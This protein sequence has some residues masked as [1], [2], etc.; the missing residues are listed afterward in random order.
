MEVAVIVY[1]II[2][3]LV[4]LVAAIPVIMG[5]YIYKDAKKR[6]MNAALWTLIGVLAPGFIGLI[7]YLIV[8]GE[9]SD[10]QCNSCGKP[11]STAFSVC[12]YC[13]APLKEKCSKCGYTLNPDWMVCANCGTEIPEEH[14]HRTTVRKKSGGLKWLLALVIAVPL[15]LMVLLFA[16]TC[17]FVYEVDQEGCSFE[18][19]D[20]PKSA[21]YEDQ[22]EILDWLSDCDAKGD[23]TYVLRTDYRMG[24]RAVTNLLVY[25]NEGYFEISTS[26]MDGGWFVSPELGIEYYASGFDSRQDYTLTACR[27]EVKNENRMWLALNDI[28]YDGNTTNIEYDLTETDALDNLLLMYFD[29]E[30]LME[31]QYCTVGIDEYL[32]GVYAVSVDLCADGVIVE[33]ET[34]Q[35]ADESEISGETFDFSHYAELDDDVE[36]TIV[37][38]LYD[39]NEAELFSSDPIPWSEDKDWEAIISFYLDEE[40]NQIGYEIF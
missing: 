11:V 27:F 14:R 35:N 39:E 13:G 24:A 36:Y 7:I 29:E 2:I 19:Y 18:Y 31:K 15:L 25:R 34:A 38:T 20:I 37:V 17:L 23:G 6:G 3:L 28:D 21:I 9:H 12:P 26:A 22:Q 4:L 30:Y 10:L 8:R 40:T 5:I 32:T 1:P 16:A 33:G